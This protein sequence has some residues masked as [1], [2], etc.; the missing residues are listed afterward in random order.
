MSAAIIAQTGSAAEPRDPCPGSG[1]PGFDR[2]G[3]LTS[4]RVGYLEASLGTRG[5]GAMGVA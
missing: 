4:W 3:S 5:Q 2:H 1:W